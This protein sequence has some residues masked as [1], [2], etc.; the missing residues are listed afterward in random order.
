MK[1]YLI[2]VAS[3]G[4]DCFIAECDGDPGRTLIKS[5]AKVFK[6]KCKAEFVKQKLKAKYPN[7]EFKVVEF[8][9]DKKI[10]I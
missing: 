3:S 4:Q 8:D 5:S 10:I 6:T 1:R 9:H 2:Q 7:R